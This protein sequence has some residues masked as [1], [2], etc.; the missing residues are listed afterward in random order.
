MKVLNP[1]DLEL[2]K[3]IPLYVSFKTKQLQAM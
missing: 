1:N 2:D 3:N